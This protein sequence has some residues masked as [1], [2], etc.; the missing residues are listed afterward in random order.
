M[1]LMPS[2]IRIMLLVRYGWH[3][4]IKSEQVSFCNGLENKMSKIS[5][6][7]L[8]RTFDNLEITFCPRLLRINQYLN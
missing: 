1:D 8:L 6:E 2:Y 3:L 5:D 7:T 4:I